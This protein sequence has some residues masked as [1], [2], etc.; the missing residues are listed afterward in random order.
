MGIGIESVI[1]LLL[2]LLNGVFALSEL[3]L[4]SRQLVVGA[5]PAAERALLVRIAR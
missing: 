1:V 5:R 4:Y 2:I 3:A